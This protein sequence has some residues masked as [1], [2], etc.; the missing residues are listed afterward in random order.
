MKRIELEPGQLSPHFFGR[1]TI[2]SLALCDE[3]VRFFE[4]H[5]ANHTKG[6]TGGGLNTE[7]KNSIDMAIRPRDL[8]QPDHEPVRNYIATLF[9]CYKDYLTQWPFLKSMLENAEIGSF[10]IQKYE[11]GGHF[12][13]L[14]SERTTVETAH[15]VLAWMTYLNDVDDGGS[16]H[17]EH[18]GLEVKPEKGKTLIWPGEWT[19][20]HK[21]NVVNSGLKYIITGWMH[22]PPYASP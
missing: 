6:R 9:E 5:Q 12:M 13:K 11:P 14:H 18:Q 17:F 20:A 7:S 3:L 2:E 10:N 1:W 4:T 21:G 19:H 8:E 16:T 15:R 22:L